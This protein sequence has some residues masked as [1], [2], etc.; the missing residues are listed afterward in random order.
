MW[1]NVSTSP[2]YKYEMKKNKIFS[3]QQEVQPPSP[4]VHQEMKS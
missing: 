2:V 3:C 1:G 4:D